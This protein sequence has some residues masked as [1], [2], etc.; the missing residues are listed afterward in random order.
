M[1]HMLSVK[2]SSI[3]RIEPTRGW[4][5]LKLRELLEYRDLIYFLIIWR[6]IKVRYKQTL[7]AAAWAI[8]QPLSTMV[9]FSVVFGKIAKMPSCSLLSL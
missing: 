1:D 7:L 3:I 9:I 4:I 2:D 8:I 5:S 6:D